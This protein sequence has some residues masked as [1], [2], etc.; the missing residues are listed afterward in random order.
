MALVIAVLVFFGI[1]S[2]F[3]C[4]FQLAVNNFMI[5]DGLSVD[6]KTGLFT[7]VASAVAWI[8]S[9]VVACYAYENF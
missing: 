4:L 2:V 9:I 6:P 7:V 8:V 5:G 1:M 3:S